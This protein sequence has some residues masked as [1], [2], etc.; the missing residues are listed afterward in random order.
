VYDR[1]H[2]EEIVN[3]AK[4]AQILLTNK[5]VLSRD[6]ISQLPDLR[7]IGVTATGF[8]CVDIEAASER[9]IPVTNVPEYGT[10]SVA[11]MV[12]AHLLNLCHHVAEHSHSVRQ[13]RWSQSNDFCFWEFPLV[14]L[15]GRTMGIVGVGRIGT[16]VAGAAAAFG[17]NVIAHDPVIHSTGSRGIVLTDLETLFCRSDVISLHCPVT[18][19]NRGFVNARL[20]SLMKR[21]AFLINTSRGQ[22]VD[23][24]ALADA[25]NSGAIAGA[26]LDVLNH[27]PPSDEC[28]LLTATNCYITPHIAWATLEARRRLITTAF[29]NAEAFLRGKPI[30][31]VNAPC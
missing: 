20:L 5:A 7:Y 28:P 16:S 3:R 26:G 13:G 8:N 22:L 11:Q 12:F 27:E 1:T 10:S 30:N 31:V 17:M 14:E 25:L 9:G 23:E 24:R 2:H 29:Q 15:S 4:G 19:H 21:T 6:A 18:D